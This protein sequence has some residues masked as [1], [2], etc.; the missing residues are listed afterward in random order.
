M[1]KKYLWGV[2]AVKKIH[3]VKFFFRG[4]KLSQM[5]AFG[6]FR[7]NKLSRMDP[8]GIFRRNKLAK[9]SSFKVLMNNV[10]WQG[11]ACGSG[12]YLEL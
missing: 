1:G 3:G 9:V 12:I 4:N 7:E 5:A 6:I 10:P 11:V 8:F 2:D